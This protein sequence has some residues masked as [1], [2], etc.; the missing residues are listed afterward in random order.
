VASKCRQAELF[1]LLGPNGAEQDYLD[2]ILCTIC[3]RIAARADQTARLIK[4]SG[5]RP[6]NI[7]S[8]YRSRA[9]DDRLTLYENLNFHGL[10]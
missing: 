4:N 5:R 8:C 7:G 3:G 1:A 10:V 6:R 9:S 2:A